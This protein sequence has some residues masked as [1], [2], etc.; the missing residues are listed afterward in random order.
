M[1]TVGLL[2]LCFAI[3]IAISTTE[4]DGSASLQ[5]VHSV[6][7]FHPYHSV[8][9]IHAC[10]HSVV[11]LHQVDVPHAGRAKIHFVETLAMPTWMVGTEPILQF[12]KPGIGSSELFIL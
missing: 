1:F 9:T 3:P 2:Q 8:D 6:E 4:W 10:K 7:I 12:V 11:T 5:R